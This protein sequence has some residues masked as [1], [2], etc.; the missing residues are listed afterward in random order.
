[1]GGVL[2]SGLGAKALNEV[3]KLEV[4][5]KNIVI[6]GDVKNDTSGFSAYA[7]VLTWTK[8]GITATARAVGYVNLN[9]YQKTE[10][11]GL[12]LIRADV[13]DEENKANI[14]GYDN[15][16]IDNVLYTIKFLKASDRRT[17]TLSKDGPEGTQFTMH[18]LL[19]ANLTEGFGEGN[20]PSISEFD[21]MLKQF[22]NSWFGGTVNIF[23][24]KNFMGLV[25]KELEE[26]RNAVTTL[27]GNS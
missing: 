24:T 10:R 14:R 8:E 6:N 15:V 22:P 23:D 16:K 17:I 25:F 13:T 2:M 26:I 9:S 19:M 11:E 7:G 12:W 21:K 20:E 18:T 5:I 3:R 1:M 27:G 4:P